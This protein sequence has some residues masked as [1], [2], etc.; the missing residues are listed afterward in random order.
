VVGIVASR[1]VERYYRPTVL[2]A[3]EEG[4]IGR[5]S[6]RSIAGLNLYDALASCRDCLERFGGHRMAA[7][8]SIKL[9]RVAEL[10]ERLEAAVSARTQ[11]EDFI[12]QTLIDAELSL[13]A[14]DAGCFADLE[15][16]EPYGMGNPEPIFL[17]RDV[18]V[19]DC[20][21]VGKTHLKLFLEHDGHRLP[22]IGFGMAD[23]SVATGD[24][25]DVL[26]SPMR[27]E[28]NGSEYI[29]LRIRDLRAHQ[30]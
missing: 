17:S 3:A 15:R 22:A 29:E 21:V 26:F 2:I 4:G 25:L 16:L 9:D 13:R 7:G 14:V 19:R 18:R 23:A 6:G 28:W 20:R 8:L 1:L 27:S 10:S 5:G 12:P 30:A 24:R 11:P